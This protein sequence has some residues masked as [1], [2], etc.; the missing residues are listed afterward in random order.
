M[1]EPT[2][3]NEADLVHLRRAVEIAEETE[4]KGNC[5]VGAVITLRGRSIAEAGNSMLVPQY[6]PIWHAEMTALSKVPEDLWPRAT[7]MTCYSTLEPCVMCTGSLLLHG[8]GRIVFGSADCDAGGAIILSHLPKFYDGGRGVPE[9][10]GPC[11][12]KEC[13]PLRERTHRLLAE[14]LGPK[15]P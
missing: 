13:D 15:S 10:L 12:A 11:M 2:K 1:Q 7:E 5:A 8:F 6:N 4:A 3:V 14:L 9:W